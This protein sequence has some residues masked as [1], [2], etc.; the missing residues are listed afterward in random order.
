MSSVIY[1]MSCKQAGGELDVSQHL[2]QEV[3]C[4]DAIR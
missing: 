1:G 2:W 4:C 3:D